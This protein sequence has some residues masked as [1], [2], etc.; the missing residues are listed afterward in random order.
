MGPLNT[1]AINADKVI[2]LSSNLRYLFIIWKLIGGYVEE[3]GSMQT[4]K[5]GE[6][7][8]IRA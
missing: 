5:E 1:R 8:N 6:K 3:G 7:C 2:L 4:I